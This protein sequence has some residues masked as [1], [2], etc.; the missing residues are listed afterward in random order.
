VVC[1]G[2]DAGGPDQLGGVDLGQAHDGDASASA[3]DIHGV[4][5]MLAATSGRRRPPDRALYCR[6]RDLAEDR[7]GL[8]GLAGEHGD[9]LARDRPLPS[10]TTNSPAYRP[11]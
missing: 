8:E 11:P 4:V 2:G 3:A 6:S 1:S 9:G 7:G 10:E 5:E